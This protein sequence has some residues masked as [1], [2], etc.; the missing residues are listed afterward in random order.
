MLRKAVLALSVILCSALPALSACSDDVA[1]APAAPAATV[2]FDPSATFAEE[3]AFFDFPY[4]SDLR[5]T[6]EGAP[7]VAPF[8]DP[9]VPI[10]AGLKKGAQDRKGF[11]VVPVGY[12]RL[13]A[14]P[15]PRDPK[16]LIDGGAKA[17]IVLV[18]VDPASP[19]RGT[20]IP[21]VAET[22]NP[23]RYAP[24]WMIA[25][26]A[27]PGIVLAP[28]RKY[29]FFI[30]R[31]VGLEGGGELTPPKALTAPEDPRLRDLYA[32]FWE[33]VDKLGV[34]RDRIAA[35]TVFTTGDVV[36]DTAALGDK[37][38]AAHQPEITDL[39]L[40]P[41]PGNKLPSMCHVRGKIVLPQFQKGAP[42]FD[43]DGLFE[44]G[45][46]GAPVKQRDETVNVSITVPKTKM[47][48]GGYPLVVY[49]HGSGGV[50]R[51]HV[52]GGGN[53][54]GDGN[55][56]WPST[57]LTEHGFAVAGTAL[58]ISPERVPG[59]TDYAYINPD[60]LVAIRDTFRQGVLESRIFISALERLRIPASVVAGCSTE[61]GEIRF[62]EGIHAQGQSMGGMYT[63]LVSA[64][65]PRIK[66]SVP[67][68]AGGYWI[69]FLLETSFVEN[70]GGLL[71]VVLKTQ[72]RM[73]FLHPAL[74]IGETAIEAA[75]SIVSAN[76]LARRPLAGHPARYI[77]EPVGKDDSYF[78]TQIYDAMVL[79]YGHPRAGDEV[80]P[81][82]H[83]AQKLVGLDAV[84]SYPVKA[85]LK[86]ENGA[87]YTGIVVQYAS[88]GTF[89]SHQIYRRVP[90]VQH[91]YACFHESFRK[92]GVAVVSPP[93]PTRDAPCAE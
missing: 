47:P 44:I 40:E 46:G 79:S 36:A 51:Q 70:I 35:A 38:I 30:T 76:R 39:V 25:I 19:E 22:P 27:R 2:A 78:P 72:E 29:A 14:K 24:E 65:D 82:M 58:P 16:A 49:F 26:A 88:D 73:S 89:D 21:V 9:G 80:W 3:N 83:D 64:V 18:D 59:A 5:L 60:N 7:D 77:Y 11:P 81:S 57:V 10:L 87:Q 84:A 75:D 86:S 13:T 93:A 52:D 50:S 63:N 53:D 41:D 45:E 32:P 54:E 71:S 20:T 90:A 17:P 33:T 28:K 37:V 92:T 1:A 56:V 91:Q 34:A 55:S 8:P 74:H 6:P 31:D 85:N 67:T 42:P 69:Y 4:P 62:A 68:G 61:T 48:A 43:T 12:F 23:D 15:A 66:V